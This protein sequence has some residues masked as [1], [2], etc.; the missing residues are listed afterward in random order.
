MPNG[1]IKPPAIS[2]NSLNNP[3]FRVKSDGVVYSQGTFT[4]NKTINLYNT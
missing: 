3:T 4:P 1:S 2:D